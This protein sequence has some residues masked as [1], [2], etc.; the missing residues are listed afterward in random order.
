MR[1]YDVIISGQEKLIK[2][3]KMTLAFYIT[4]QQ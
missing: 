3:M 4:S 2:P 1:K